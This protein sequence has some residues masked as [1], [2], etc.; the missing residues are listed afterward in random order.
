MPIA[1]V[2]LFCGAGGLTCGLR[3]GGV[4]VRA[5]VD[6]DPACAHPYSHNNQAEFLLKKIEDVTGDMLKRFYRPGEIKL[7]AG[8]APCQ[9]FSSY[10]QGRDHTQDAKWHLLYH[11]GRVVRELHPDLVTMENVLNLEEQQVFKDFVQTLEDLEYTVSHWKVACQEYGLPQQRQRLVLLASQFGPVELKRPDNVATVTVRDVL[12]GLEPLEAGQ[13]SERDPLHKASLLSPLNMERIKASRPGG[14]W[15]DWPEEM[16]AACHIKESGKTYPSVY[17]RMSW[18]EPSPTITTQ[19]FGFGNGRFGHPEQDRGLSLREG[20]ILQTFPG[21]YE[22]VPA[23]QP[24][25]MKVM[26]RLIGNAVPVRLGEIIAESLQEHVQ[27][28]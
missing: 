25:H 1:A 23:G 26:G 28:A 7:L 11:F 16:R 9:P 8:C 2:D 18:D 4:T 12:S 24:V 17:G 13:T 6:A 3:R 15:R 27:E 10:T 21:D 19:F 5:G 20:A 22:F 14:T